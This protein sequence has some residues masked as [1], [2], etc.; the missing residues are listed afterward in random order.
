MFL[1]A[2]SVFPQD[3]VGNTTVTAKRE[4]A[5][6]KILT[7][8]ERA[9]HR[10]LLSQEKLTQFRSL[11][12]GYS[13]GDNSSGSLVRYM[14]GF[15]YAIRQ[16]LVAGAVFELSRYQSN[17]RSL[18]EITPAFRLNWKS[19]KGSFLSISL[20]LPPQR[21]SGNILDRDLMLKS[22]WRRPRPIW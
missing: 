14:H 2:V 3:S 20:R 6:G 5:A 9:E 12:L 22:L 17:G 1:F 11:T 13:A 8:P 4:S 15:D 18:T 19:E 7:M 21:L 16:N 10:S